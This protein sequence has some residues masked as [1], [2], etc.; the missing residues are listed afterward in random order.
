MILFQMILLPFRSQTTTMVVNDW[1][2]IIWIKMCGP[3]DLQ[4]LWSF[5]KVQHPI[6]RVR[7]VD[8]CPVCSLR[9]SS[10]SSLCMIIQQGCKSWILYFGPPST[11]RRRMAK[12]TTGQETTCWVKLLCF[13]IRS[14]ALGRSWCFLETMIGCSH[15]GAF[16]Y[17]STLN[18]PGWPLFSLVP[19]INPAILPAEFLS[20]PGCL[21][22]L[23][24]GN[25]S[26]LMGRSSIFNGWI[27]YFYIFYGHVQ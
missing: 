22:V 15:A 27:N 26:K 12:N 17:S 19:S 8:P 9:L 14:M 21:L 5:L 1:R 24:S 2:E 3:W 6:L 23:P 16:L 18:C 11:L 13:V 25:L 7:N 20:S 4:M 10:E